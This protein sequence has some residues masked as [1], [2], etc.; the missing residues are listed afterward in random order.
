MHFLNDLEGVGGATPKHVI[1]ETFPEIYPRSGLAVSGRIATPDTADW[2][3]Q[4]ALPFLIQRIG[5]IRAHCHSC[6]V[7]GTWYQVLGT[8]YLVFGTWYLIP[9]TK[10][11]VPSI[12]YTVPNAKCLVPSTQYLVPSA[13]QVPGTK[14]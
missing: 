6:T 9:S 4:G 12:K 5:C 8:W 13:Y 3:H 11:L 1:E 2:L 7:L 14:Y 10:Y